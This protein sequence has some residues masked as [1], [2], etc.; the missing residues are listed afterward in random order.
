MTTALG[1]AEMPTAER[2][3]YP[4]RVDVEWHERQRRL[5]NLP[6]LIGT[7]IR[8]FLL[9][10]NLLVF[11]YLQSAF[12]IAFF[13]STFGILFT[14]RYPRGLFKIEVGILRWTTNLTTYLLHLF[15]EYP[16]MDLDH[17]PD[18][19]VTLEVDYPE[20]PSR[21]L[22]FPVIGLLV[23]LVLVIPHVVILLFLN[24]I[25]SLLLLIA[26]FAIL[27]TGRFPRGIHTF[28]VGYV[29]WST[30][31]NGYLLAFTDRYPPFSLT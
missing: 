15:D 9:I 2:P 25:A 30:R 31:V 6:F 18:G 16:P 8:I 23:K 17:R 26:E 4:I 11:Y 1:T 20:S 27:F 12:L 13:A 7:L 14:G 5:T 19:S 22:N 10:P 21:W 28:I 29:R 24:V 3:I